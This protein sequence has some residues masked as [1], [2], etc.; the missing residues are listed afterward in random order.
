MATVDLS[1]A[2]A[3]A[4]V[5]LGTL[6]GLPRRLALTLAELRHLAG[7]A[8]DAPLPFDVTA[9]KV[10]SSLD[11]RL[12]QSRTS[13]EDQAYIEALA[14]LH[15]P[16][17]SLVKRGLVVDGVADAGVLGAIG[18]LAKPSLAVDLDVTVD[19]SR[20]TA[21]HRHTGTAVATLAT[22]DGLVFELAW[23]E[24]SQWAGEL[25]RVAAVP[26]DFELDSS[27]VPALVDLPYELIDGAGEA[28]RTQR[29]DLVPVIV[30]A[31]FGQVIDGDGKPVA[32]GLVGPM[33]S[34][35]LSE[36]RGR[37]RGLAADVSEEGAPVVGVV[38]WILLEDG[39]RSLRAH[40]SGDERRVEVRRV[41]PSDLG[42]L[43]APVLA[44]V[45]A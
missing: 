44:E 35:L 29:G 10:G 3:A 27:Q 11:D 14:A 23:F 4:P 15:E 40:Q 12:G 22:A 17:D 38:S 45:T 19:G 9:P 24:P 25:A 30:A 31:H 39:W 21:W 42:S 16:T 2:P 37:L 1:V 8:G 18:L 34:A 43:L 20:A 7:L 5:D 32:D 33:I 26:D 28:L 41:E 6:E 13:I 36:T